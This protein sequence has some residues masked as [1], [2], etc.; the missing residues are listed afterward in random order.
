MAEK[1]E[2]VVH[3]VSKEG[4]SFDV[5]LKIALMSE[6]VKTMLDDEADA[7]EA[8][9]APLPNVSSNILSLTIEFLKHMAVEPMT[10]IEKVSSLE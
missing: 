1:G 10:D 2:V 9:E 3:L 4:E 7:D 6:L 5:P 8:Q